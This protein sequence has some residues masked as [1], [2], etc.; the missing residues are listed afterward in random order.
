MSTFQDL[1]NYI[2]YSFGSI[3]YVI[4]FIIPKDEN[5]W[6]FGAWFGD[7]YSDNSKYLF[8]YVNNNHPEIR[9]V[10]LT[11]DKKTLKLIKD[12]KF[13]VVFSKSVKGYII[14]LRA[15]VGV[16]S[17]GI[18]D[19]IP[20]TSG[21]MKI[22][23][24]WHGFPNK[25]LFFDNPKH[26][27]HNLRK[28]VKIIYK[29]FPFLIRDFRNDNLFIASS[30]I[31][32]ELISIRFNV[33]NERVKITGFPRLDSFESKNEKPQIFDFLAELKVKGKK[34]GIYLPTHRS[35][36]NINYNV[37]S[38]L[39]TNINHINT[40]LKEM[41]VFLLIKFHYFNINEYKQNCDH[42]IFIQDQDIN[43][44]IYTILKYTDFLITDYSSIFFDYLLLNNP[45]I[46]FQPDLTE[47]KKIIDL[48]YDIDLFPGHKANNWDN[49]IEIIEKLFGNNDMYIQERENLRKK[50]YK[51]SD[52]KNS[53][54]VFYEIINEIKSN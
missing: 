44:D 34:I 33:P 25:K 24:L 28:L 35:Y 9:A 10:W 21:K 1:K 16:L 20:Y 27:L 48:H 39:K 50:A 32:R 7:K 14:S 54:R 8:E 15:N 45:I 53:K 40:K 30:N 5:L 6:V 38:F 51:Y 22:V 3:I 49:V 17:T 37:S 47:Y 11:K 13:E 42:I 26:S 4:S 31:S 46:F 36:D 19:I 23:Q 52:S 43:Q 2:I 29:F 18:D 12:K 41:G